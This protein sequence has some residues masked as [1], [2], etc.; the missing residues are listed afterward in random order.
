MLELLHLFSLL[1][2]VL[3]GFYVF[4]A[5]PRSRANQTFAAFIAFLALWTVK[6]LVFW[7]FSHREDFPAGWWAATSFVI[8]LLMQYALAIFA[9]VF[10]GNERT[11]R[12]RAAVLFSPGLILVPA[13]LA[14]LLWRN[15]S[16]DGTNFSISLTPLAY[17][18]VVYVYVVFGFGAAVLFRK[19]RTFRGTQEGQQLGAILWA[20]SITVVLKTLANI[21]LPYFGIYALLPYSSIFV[22]PGVL[23]YAYAIS[24]F[25]LFSLQ[26]A[27]DQFRLFPITYKVALSIA[28][29]AII[30]FA[31]FQVPIVWWAFRDGMDLY[32]WRKYL[33]FSVISALVPNLLL[34]LLI[35]RSI[36]RPLQRLTVAAVKVTDGEYGTEADLRKS[37]DEIGLL[38]ESF[39]EMSRKMLS[40]IEELRKLNEQ[41]IRTEKLA[42]LGTLSAGVAHEVN[43]PLASISSLI[44]M[45]ER[46]GGID[47]ATS[48]KLGLIQT[49]ILRIKSVT[50]DMMDFARAR[51]AARALIDVN[52][53]VQTGLRLA[54]FDKQFQKL[55][56][57]T[58]LDP[59]LP[60]IM[61]DSDQL[62]QVFLNLLLNARDAMPD[63]GRLSVQSRK[64]GGNVEV[65]IGDSGP[66]I[67]KDDLKKI[68]D[69]FYTTKSSGRGTGL[70]LAVCYG[71]VTA[72]GGSIEADS[73]SEGTRFAVTLPIGEDASESSDS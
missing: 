17:A 49:Q 55:D 37:N 62:Q 3:L 19:Y 35:V 52:D 38:A 71:I 32:A 28:S 56:I 24:N 41:L 30:S 39:N 36:S 22:L 47:E 29:V 42:A 12:K 11:P 72:H 8:S 9:W 44:Q 61:A 54:G 34:V 63:G 7:N 58:F 20:L 69:P 66:G 6:D 23:I 26:T 5:D 14:G 65:S 53:V 43:N 50:K 1:L 27:L 31:I 2:L 16:Y 21:A 33:V 25:R 60:K 67:G 73:S 46:N 68:F 4:V 10:P 64:A 15:V 59:A 40:D 51:P 45:I 57:S 13:A 18:F 48:E 70:G